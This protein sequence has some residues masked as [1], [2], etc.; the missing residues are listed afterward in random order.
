M[1]YR[2]IKTLIKKEFNYGRQHSGVIA[3]HFNQ[4]H[5]KTGEFDSSISKKI[6][7]AMNVR[8]KSDYDDFFIASKN[9]AEIQ[10]QQ[11]E[12]I[13]KDVEKYVDSKM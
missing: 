4:Y 12:E 1:Y 6:T 3:A 13:I 9:D 10:V 11:A 5:V 8:Q 7:S 2:F